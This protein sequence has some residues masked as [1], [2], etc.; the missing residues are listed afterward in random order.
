MDWEAKERE[1]EAQA[2]ERKKEYNR[3]YQRIYMAKKREENGVQYTRGRY[4]SPY[5]KLQLNITSIE[6]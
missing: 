4:L 3:N 1:T 5:D 6:N 2:K